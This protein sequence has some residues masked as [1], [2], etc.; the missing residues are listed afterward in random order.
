MKKFLIPAGFKEKDLPKD[1]I[2]E[3]FDD[4]YTFMAVDKVV[5]SNKLEWIRK[6]TDIYGENSYS[7]YSRYLNPKH[8]ERRELR[9]RINHTQ[10]DFFKG[11]KDATKRELKKKVIIFLWNNFPYV[12][13][14][15]YMNG[16]LITILR[17]NSDVDSG[18]CKEKIPDF[19]TPGE[20]I[21]ENEAYYTN[22]IV[23][24]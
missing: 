10:Y 22:K 12:I 13:E 7:H 18:C 17:V 6:R 15:F 11:Q 16:I 21:S 3:V 2:Y 8:E 4:K 24:R 14:S 5:E 1:C 9:R 19:I 20:D 23:E